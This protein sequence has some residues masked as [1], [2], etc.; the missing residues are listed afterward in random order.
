MNSLEIDF[1]KFCLSEVINV[2]LPIQKCLYLGAALVMFESVRLRGR[3][4]DI[5]RCSDRLHS[6]VTNQKFCKCAFV[7]QRFNIVMIKS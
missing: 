3:Q 4:S 6:T 5:E 7:F 2:Q 1:F